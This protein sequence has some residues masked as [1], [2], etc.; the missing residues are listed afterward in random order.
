MQRRFP[1]G[2]FGVNGKTRLFFTVVGWVPSKMLRTIDPRNERP[3]KIGPRQAR[4]AQ[5]HE[6]Y[7]VFIIIDG[8]IHDMSWEAMAVEWTLPEWE[9]GIQ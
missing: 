4:R 6:P 9:R 2:A 1:P 7:D 8:T 3:T 5:K